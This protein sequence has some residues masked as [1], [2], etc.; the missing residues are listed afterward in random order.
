MTAAAILNKSSAVAE[1]GDFGHNRYGMKTGD[2]RAPFAG[3]VNPRI[4]QCGLGRDILPYQVTSSSIQSFG[5]NRHGSKI[6]G[7]ASFMGGG[8]KSPSSTMWP[9]PKPTSIPNAILIHPAVWPQKALAEHRGEA[10][11]FLGRGSWVPIQ[12]NVAWTEAHLHAK[13]HLDPSSRLAT[14]DIGRKLGGSVPFLG[15][16]AGC[17]CNTKSPGPMPISIPSGILIHPTIWP[18]QIWAENWRTVP[19]WRRGSWVS[20]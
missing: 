16:G 19:V 11:P 12:S 13:C 10:L 8:A 18:Q 14:I 7:C 5:H 1:M 15:G 4:T 6:R 2:C 3:E 17:P 9:K 20:I